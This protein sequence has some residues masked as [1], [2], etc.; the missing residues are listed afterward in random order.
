MLIYI[1]TYSPL[2]GVNTEYDEAKNLVTDIE[3]SFDSY[4]LEQKRETGIRELSYFGSNK[5]RYQLEV[6]MS[7]I[8]KVPKQWSSKSQKKTHRR[9][10]TPFVEENLAR[11]VEAEERYCFHS[12]ITLQ[13]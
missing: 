6:P 4:L 2:P 5:D 8:Q 7:Q 9:F 3:K 12:L 11:L 13:V 1:E 10:R